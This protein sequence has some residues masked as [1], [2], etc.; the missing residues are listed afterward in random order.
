MR[1]LKFIDRVRVIFIIC[2]TCIM[3]SMHNMHSLHDALRASKYSPLFTKASEG[4]VPPPA[5]SS[6]GELERCREEIAR[7]QSAGPSTSTCAK[8]S[9]INGAGDPSSMVRLYSSS[10]GARFREG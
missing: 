2:I 7:L 4:A 1:F 6:E 10:F 3:H 8:C 9:L 5:A